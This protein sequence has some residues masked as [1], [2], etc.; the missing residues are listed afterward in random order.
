MFKKLIGPSFAVGFINHSYC[1]YDKKQYRDNIRK[2]LT[3]KEFD[4][5]FPNFKPYKILANDMIHHGYKY[6]IGINT[7]NEFKNYSSCMEGGFYLADEID[8]GNYLN[9]GNKLGII[10][11]PDDTL[12][13]L[14][15][16]KIKVNKLK[17]DEVHD[18][19][20]YLNNTVNE[21]LK[22]NCVKNDGWALKYIKNP[23]K[24]VQL[25]AVKNDGLAINYIKNPSK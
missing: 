2:T 23:S 9:Y 21:E 20:H 25:E 18:L 6:K 13:Y 1:D 5:L 11:I 4:K 22:L 17:L 10:T 12:I 3:K 15:E 14:E 8:I 24:V 16:E 7:V 19:K